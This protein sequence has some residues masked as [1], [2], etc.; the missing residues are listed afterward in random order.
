[1]CAAARQVFG[2]LLAIAAA[3]ITL[4]HANPFP[5][6]C[7]LRPRLR[8]RH[9]QPSTLNPEF[10][11]VWA[12]MPRS[13]WSAHA[14]PR[15]KASLWPGLCSSGC[16]AGAVHPWL[17]GTGPSWVPCPCSASLG[18][19][20]SDVAG[21]TVLAWILPGWGCIRDHQIKAQS[22]GQALPGL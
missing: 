3:L 1:M 20:T 9:P 7:S 11:G 10:D 13:V 19:S 17:A 22:M 2:L 6:R 12:P 16:W 8:L 21:R 18:T 4:T 5:R 14:M 15:V